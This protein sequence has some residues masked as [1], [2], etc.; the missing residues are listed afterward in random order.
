MYIGPKM[1]YHSH[2]SRNIE[3]IMVYMLLL[4]GCIHIVFDLFNQRMI[5]PG[6]K[7]FDRTEGNSAEYAGTGFDI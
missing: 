5:M 4:I 2:I 1:T 6:Q 7:T 3:H